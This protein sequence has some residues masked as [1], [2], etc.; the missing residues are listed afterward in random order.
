MRR[1]RS[2]SRKRVPKLEARLRRS[3]A[4]ALSTAAAITDASGS[5]GIEMSRCCVVSSDHN[6]AKAACT[7]MP[8][9]RASS[10]SCG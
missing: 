2:S 6:S 7:R 10:P 5:C 1:A 4:N 8:R 9:S 3:R